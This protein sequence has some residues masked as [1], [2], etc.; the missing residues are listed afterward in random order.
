[1]YKI[2]IVDK[3]TKFDT[4]SDEEKALLHPDHLEKMKQVDYD[5]KHTMFMFKRD[6]ETHPKLYINQNYGEVECEYTFLNMSEVKPDMDFDQFHAFASVGG[7]GTALFLAKFIKDQPLVAINSNPATSVGHICQH[8][9]GSAG[10]VFDM[11]H[12]HL[13]QAMREV[14]WAEKG[15]LVRR[16]SI[17]RLQLVVGRTPKGIFLNDALFTNENPAEMSVYGI[18]NN[19]QREVQYSSG[20]WI[21]T[22]MGSTGAIH[23]AGVTPVDKKEKVLL[24]KTREPYEG[25]GRCWYPHGHLM[26]D[27]GDHL[28]ITARCKGMYFYLDGSY[29]KIPLEIGKEAFIMQSPYPL[30]LA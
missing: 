11:L 20:V 5:H 26:M 19:G 9:V 10:T 7:D 29:N 18:D 27:G 8:Q 28:S 23:S 25:H 2:L 21:S 14:I 30:N 12:Y 17:P 24:W 15:E 4:L 13:S 1:M 6:M 16:N 22:A 3:I